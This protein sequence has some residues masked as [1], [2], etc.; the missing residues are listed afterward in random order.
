MFYDYICPKCGEEKE[1]NHSMLEDPIIYCEKCVEVVMKRVIT[2]GAGT[3]FK[4]GGWAQ[5][6]NAFKGDFAGA[7]KTSMKAR[8]EGDIKK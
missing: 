8:I 1:I 4:G 5:D 2:G 3:H 7:S 6:A